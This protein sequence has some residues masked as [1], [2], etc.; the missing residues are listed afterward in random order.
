MWEC[1]AGIWWDEG[2]GV[3]DILHEE[4]LPYAPRDFNMST[5]R[6]EVKRAYTY[7]LHINEFTCNM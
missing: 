4:E 2:S 1:A 3:P 6:T 7:V 5:R